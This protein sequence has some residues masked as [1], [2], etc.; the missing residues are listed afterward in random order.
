M[1]DPVPEETITTLIFW[2]TSDDYVTLE[3]SAPWEITDLAGNHIFAPMALPEP[4][5]ILP[6]EGRT[7]DYELRD[8]AMNLLDPGDY[9]AHIH[10]EAS[11]S[12]G[13]TLPADAV[14]PFT[15][16][17][18]PDGEV[19]WMVWPR[20]N[21]T[22]M[23]V[24]MTLT[25]ATNDTIWIRDSAPWWIEDVDRNYVDSADMALLAI[26]PIPPGAT[27]PWS[28]DEQ[29]AAGGPVPGGRYYAL[30]EYSRTNY[31][32]TFEPVEIDFQLLDPYEGQ[33]EPCLFVEATNYQIPHPAGTDVD[34]RFTNCAPTT[35]G[36]RCQYSWWI[37]TELGI[38]IYWPYVLWAYTTFESLETFDFVWPETMD[39]TG[40]SV[41]SGFYYACVSFTDERFLTE[42]IVRSQPIAV[43]GSQG[44]AQWHP[45]L[46]APQ[47][48]IAPNPFGRETS[49]SFTVAE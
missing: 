8:D 23:S 19:V 26:W 41:P 10:Y 16:T 13:G 46:H 39:Y 20:I 7:W 38:P 44:I 31:P 2:N 12:S 18:A 42:Y 25:N 3:S 35:V 28:W 6:G 49:I 36:M 34:F 21:G 17:P 1:P 14:E 45:P 15:I 29:Y 5:M 9:L 11:D 37:A 47:T 40:E 48:R 24:A 27:M 4:Q 33:I 22:E 30:I 43:Q 32:Y